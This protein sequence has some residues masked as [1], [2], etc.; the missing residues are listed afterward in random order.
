VP[1]KPDERADACPNGMVNAGGKCTTPD[2]TAT[3]LCR[4]TDADD[5]KAQCDKGHAGSC[6]ELGRILAEKSTVLTRAANKDTPESKELGMKSVELM[7]KGC[8]GGAIQACVYYGIAMSDGFYIPE[9]DRGAIAIFDRGCAGGSDLGCFFLAD[10]Y[11]YGKNVPSDEARAA[12]LDRKACAG[13]N[14]NA[15]GVA[16]YLADVS[17][18][19]DAAPLYQRGCDGGRGYGCAKLGERFEMGRGGPKDLAR[20]KALYA[21][22][23]ELGDKYACFDSGRLAYVSSPDSA[24]SA[25][26]SGCHADTSDADTLACA[27]LEL[28]YDQ[29]VSDWGAAYSYTRPQALE[30]LCDRGDALGCGHLGIDAWGGADYTK[31]KG[32]DGTAQLKKACGMGDK[33]AC[34]MVGPSAKPSRFMASAA[35]AKPDTAKVNAPKTP[36]TTTPKPAKP[37]P[38]RPA[39]KGK[40]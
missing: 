7:K 39:K 19:S 4:S 3:H 23:C 17:G 37:A 13:G 1:F 8:D 36:T 30:R 29:R 9:D 27:V 11:L 6:G 26:V 31:Q 25:F 20:A 5:C 40:R 10:Q 24:K 14:A 15:C 2:A 16:G 35:A 12:L 34:A 22:G 28:A 18:A 33:F 38:K 32:I 21:R